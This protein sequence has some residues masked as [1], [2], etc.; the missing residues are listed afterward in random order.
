[1]SVFQMERKWANGTSHLITLRGESL[2][3]TYDAFVLTF[4]FESFNIFP[5][6][7]LRD[8]LHPAFSEIVRAVN[9][10]AKCPSF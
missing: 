7:R 1:M 9:K 5:R 8:N 3:R 2:V 10:A 4:S 6:L